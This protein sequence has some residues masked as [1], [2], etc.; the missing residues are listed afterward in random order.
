MPR[1]INLAAGVAA[2][3]S[4]VP[5][6]DICVWENERCKRSS[7]SYIMVGIRSW[8]ER[9]PEVATPVDSRNCTE[10]GTLCIVHD[11]KSSM[12]WKFTSR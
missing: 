6:Q 11:E 7:I 12:R 1:V 8:F 2:V 5:E 3:T 4:S 9:L 10:Y